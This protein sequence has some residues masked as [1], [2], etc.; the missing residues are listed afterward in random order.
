M[1]KEDQELFEKDDAIKRKLIRQ[2]FSKL[3]LSPKT[4]AELKE[5]PIYQAMYKYTMW[6]DENKDDFIFKVISNFCFEVAK[7]RISKAILA[8]AIT[9][10]IHN[11]PDE[12]AK[13]KE[14]PFEEEED[15]S[16][17]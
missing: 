9:E 5:D 1:N 15:E 2:S 12:I 6:A 4:D 13:D 7:Y 17:D 11:H 16:A 10:Y 8:K 14:R 3:D